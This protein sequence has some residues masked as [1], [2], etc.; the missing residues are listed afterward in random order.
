MPE[1]I[2]VTGATGNTGLPICRHLAREHDVFA[3]ARFTDPA[4]RARLE[5]AGAQTIPI[6]LTGD[7]S[8]LPTDF[9]A[10]VHL[11]AFIGP[12][13]DVDHAMTVN[14]ETPGLLMQHLRK[15]RAFLHLSAAAVYAAPADP[16]HLIKETDPLDPT[17]RRYAPTYA[18]TKIAAEGVV[19]TMARALD[20][21]TTIARLN[22]AYDAN[23]GQPAFQL[24]WIRAGKPIPVGEAPVVRS[25]ISHEDMARQ[26]LALLDAATVPATIVNWGGDEAVSKQEWCTYLGEVAG[27]AAVL[28]PGNN[29]GGA[30][31]DPARRR[32]ITGPCAVG[33]RDGMRRMVQER[34]DAGSARSD[35]FL[36]AQ[37]ASPTRA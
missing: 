35:A 6:D 14:A 4:A 18:V 32:S 24:D 9:T 16:W 28:E 10:V 33:W 12:G 26:T 31:M 15:A 3:A 11:A 21:P 22:V 27:R 17:P 23:G 5:D 19:R 37:S 25:P 8:A 2:L 1:K 36:G 29:E 13:N 30:A 34:P 7:L 20:L